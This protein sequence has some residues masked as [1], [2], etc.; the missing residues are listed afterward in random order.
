MS[1]I[2]ARF[3]SPLSSQFIAP[4]SALSRA[5]LVEPATASVS[6]D[7]AT[8]FISQQLTASMPQEGYSRSISAAPAAP[9]SIQ[10]IEILTQKLT[11]NLELSLSRHSPSTDSMLASATAANS[12]SVDASKFLDHTLTKSVE[13]IAAQPALVVPNLILSGATGALKLSPSPDNAA[14][15]HPDGLGVLTLSETIN[16]AHAK[17]P[18]TDGLLAMSIPASHSSGSLSIAL[19]TYAASTDSDLPPALEFK[20]AA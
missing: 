14:N 16:L 13:R 4:S 15:Q 20:V 1:A 2:I 18:L 11:Q 17:P 9:I 10:E 5:R 19:N 7:A 8:I 3:S 6:Q 12:T